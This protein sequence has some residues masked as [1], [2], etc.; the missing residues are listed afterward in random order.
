MFFSYRAIVESTLPQSQEELVEARKNL[1]LEGKD[2]HEVDWKEL[3]DWIRIL[4]LRREGK[5]TAEIRNSREWFSS[6]EIRELCKTIDASEDEIVSWLRGL[7]FPTLI[8]S[9]S[10]KNWDSDTKFLHIATYTPSI[11]DWTVKRLLEPESAIEGAVPGL[12]KQKNYRQLAKSFNQYI[13]LLSKLEG[14]GRI[15]A[16][17]LKRIADELGIPLKR[18]RKWALESQRP[19][20]IARFEDAF[21]NKHIAQAIRLQLGSF[22]SSEE[23]RTE[24]ERRGFDQLIDSWKQGE[25]EWKRL[26]LY[27]KFLEHLE[28]GTLIKDIARLTGVGQSTIY[29]WTKMHLPYPLFLLLREGSDRHRIL[30]DE[31]VVHVFKPK[32]FGIEIL[33]TSQLRK[34]ISTY[35]PGLL[36]ESVIDDLIHEAG[37]HVDLVNNLS[38]RT[39]IT[40][41]DLLDMSRKLKIPYSSARRWVLDGGRPE[42]YYYIERGLKTAKGA[43]ALRDV[44]STKTMDEIKKMLNLFFLKPFLETWDN[45][46]FL[47]QMT[48][49]YLQFLNL[50]E[51]GFTLS[52]IAE[53]IGVGDRTISDWIQGRLPLLLYMLKEMPTEV[54][55]EGK[56]WLPLLMKGRVFRKYIQVPKKIADYSDILDV[57]AQFHDTSIHP[58]DFMYLIGVLVSDGYIAKRGKT[59][60]SL[61]LMLG[62]SYSWSENL[63]HATRVI[64]ETLGFQNS[65][66]HSSNGEFETIELRSYTTP[67]F[68]WVRS[69]LLGLAPD[70]I[71]TYTPMSGNWLLSAPGAARF[72]FL[73]GLADGD[74]WASFF[75]Q[76]AGI[77]SI[78]NQ[79]FIIKL[80][81]TLD[82][83]GT[84]VKSGVSINRKLSIQRAAS[85]PL[86]R[87]AKS[88]LSNLLILSQMIGTQSKHRK[89]SEDEIQIIL[90]LRKK[91]TSHGD[92]A[93]RL[94]KDI[95]ISRSP[96]SIGK[97]LK[98]R[99][100]KK[101]SPPD[102]N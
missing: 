31:H 14:R 17:E 3:E 11:P 61:R 46:H 32:A 28:R 12:A 86:F 97:F 33:K 48:G 26:N 4:S 25:K 29:Y 74:G 57:L 22:D 5:L 43:K 87:H 35:M 99:N 100:L 101:T 10:L 1:N 62:K 51:Q 6:E 85:L 77:A 66:Y 82:I 37:S 2:F 98:R 79:D 52:A 53:K 91:G 73:Q 96:S 39:R 88:R 64:I 72:G 44:L 93:F 67:F 50:I 90:A 70:D 30:T 18:A 63:I 59:S 80:L 78:S 20:A 23:V 71:K 24:L 38:R 81:E 55:S 89:F 76:R 58:E 19:I 41:S 65:I 94:W 92:I 36:A 21:A 8:R 40:A 54:P 69:A 15:T 83:E 27:F 13:H 45:Y 42:I 47:E 7:S 60:S 68:L 16:K 9:E 102:V 75:D 56:Y 49:N 95:G 34:M 84:R